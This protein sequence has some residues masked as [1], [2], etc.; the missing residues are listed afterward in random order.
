MKKFAA[1]FLVFALLFLCACASDL[2][3][4]KQT[5]APPGLNNLPLISG[6]SSET[7][8]TTEPVIIKTWDTD[9]L[10]EKFPE[11]PEGTYGF[12]IEKGDPATDAGN[13]SAEWVRIGFT[14]PE[15]NIFTFTNELINLGYIGSIKLF[16]QDG[17]YPMG[18]K[19]YWQNGEHIVRINATSIDDSSNLTLIMDIVPCVDNFPTVLEEYFPKFN[20]YTAETGL[21]C[22]HDSA[23]A[24]ITNEFTGKLHDVW[25]WEFCFSNG[26]VGVTYEEFEAY[27]MALSEAGFVGVVDNETLDGCNVL[28]LDMTKTTEDGE[29]GAFIL[30]NQTLR[31][32]DVAYTNDLSLYI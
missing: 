9:L 13:F 30:F 2:T 11:P 31:T 3:D 6:Q 16:E 5:S 27:Y 15:T 10:P 17:Y 21:Y 25:H 23:G 4:T 18:Y 32:L 28:T 20:G 7:V 12:R 29:Y 24:S 19:G 1:I 8:P 22:A 26:F 14:C